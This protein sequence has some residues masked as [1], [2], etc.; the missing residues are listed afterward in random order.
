MSV[1]AWLLLGLISGFIA[2]KLVGGSGGLFIDLLLGV[3]G[4]FVGG[5][6]FHLIGEVGVTGLNL[7]SIF[8]SVVGAAIVLVAHHA[9]SGRRATS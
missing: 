6:A 8:V 9:I 3:V 4:A 1:V 2:S 7:W 5:A